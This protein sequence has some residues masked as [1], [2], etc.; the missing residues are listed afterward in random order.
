MSMSALEKASRRA[1]ELKSRL[2]ELNEELDQVK[3]EIVAQA[4]PLMEAEGKKS[5]Q[6]QGRTGLIEIRDGSD[7]TLGPGQ[8]VEVKTLLDG[9]F[10]SMVAQKTSYGLTPEL[11]STLKD[12]SSELGKRL[13]AI[14]P[15]KESV[16]VSIK[17][18]M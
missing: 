13:R 9:S 12:E 8:I 11:R 18:K 2:D 10:T 3:A 4:K 15:Y 7:W 1:V 14:I 5:F 17:P 16:S 6:Y